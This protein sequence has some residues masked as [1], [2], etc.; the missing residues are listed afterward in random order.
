M[1]ETEDKETSGRRGSGEDRWIW[2]SGDAGAQE[3]AA[4]RGIRESRWTWLGEEPPKRG[5]SS[6]MPRLLGILGVAA[7][8]IAG[9]AAALLVN[10]KAADDDGNVTVIHTPSTQPTTTTDRSEERRVGKEC[11]S[12]W[13]PYH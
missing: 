8:V 3:P 7:G 9:L 11:R 5:G 4:R 2:L 13:S 10:F 1:D 6:R 12:R